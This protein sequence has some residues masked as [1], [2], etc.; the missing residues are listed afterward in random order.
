MPI[1]E[2]ASRTRPTSSSTRCTPSTGSPDGAV[3]PAATLSNITATNLYGE[4]AT[5]HQPP[6]ASTDRRCRTARLV[7]SVQ[8][9]WRRGFEGRVQ[10][11]EQL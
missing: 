4:F 2:L 8:R 1:G 3:V 11:L 5:S 10:D 7:L 9:G 6:T